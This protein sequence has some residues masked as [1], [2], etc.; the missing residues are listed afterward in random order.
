MLPVKQ[1]ERIFSETISPLLCCFFRDEKVSFLYNYGVVVLP[2]PGGLGTGVSLHLMSNQAF[3]AGSRVRI[4]SYS[5]FR[6]LRGTIRTVD[7]IP[8]PDIDEPFCF[9]HIELEGAHLKEPIWFQHDEV[10]ITSLAGRNIF[11]NN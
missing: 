9:Y 2:S 7:A 6:G 11:S 4:V 5:P 10:E 1:L 8:H 3:P